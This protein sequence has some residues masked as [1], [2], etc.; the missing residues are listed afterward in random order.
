[1][2]DLSNVFGPNWSRQTMPYVYAAIEQELDAATAHEWGSDA[3]ADYL[4]ATTLQIMQLAWRRES[5][6]RRLARSR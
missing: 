5:E 2:I 4:D 1:M 6:V 3:Y